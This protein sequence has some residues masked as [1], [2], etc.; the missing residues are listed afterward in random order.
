MSCRPLLLAFLVTAGC[1]HAP[2][3]RSALE[4][5]LS[6]AEGRAHPLREA[7]QAKPLTVVFFFSAACPCQRAHDARLQALAARYGP[8]GVQFL[9][10]DSEYDATPA[11]DAREARERGY[12][13]PIWVDRGG[14]LADALAAQYATYAVVFDAQ[15][16]IRYRGGI[17]SDKNRLHRD[18]AP[19]LDEAI[20]SLLAGRAPA[21]TETR[22]LGCALRRW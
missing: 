18:A 20:Q 6:D 16:A 11:A 1:A 17:D 13:F 7:V 3:P 15:G 8:S 21:R 5:P 12:P 19:Y 10:V 22:A 2:Q 14:A 9:G 4:V